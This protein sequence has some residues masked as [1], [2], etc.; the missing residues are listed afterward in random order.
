MTG[1]FFFSYGFKSADFPKKYSSHFATS[2][3][4]HQTRWI[5]MDKLYLGSCIPSTES[6]VN[7]HLPKMGN[8]IDRL[9]IIQKCDESNK[10]RGLS[11]FS[12]VHT[13]IWM[14]R[15]NANR[16]LIEKERFYTTW[17]LHKNRTSLKCLVVSWRNPPSNTH[18]NNRWAA[19]SLMSYRPSKYNRQDMQGTAG[20][21][22][23]NSLATFS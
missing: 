5:H 14:H 7:I 13:T 11:S 16:K 20:V 4:T 8:V 22:G 19:T 12:C 6:Y 10:M 3:Y 1:I 18:Q 17:E 15:M 21:E 23:T 9:S 2:I